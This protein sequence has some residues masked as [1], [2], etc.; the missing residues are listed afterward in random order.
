LTGIN[1]YL[2]RLLF[3]RLMVQPHFHDVACMPKFTTMLLSLVKIR[4]NHRWSLKIFFS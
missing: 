1:V 4:I 3:I 2:I